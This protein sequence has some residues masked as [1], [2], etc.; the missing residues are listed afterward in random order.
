MIANSQNAVS[1]IPLR[2]Y[3]AGFSLLESLIVI[4]IVTMLALGGMNGLGKTKNHTSLTESHAIILYALENARGD[5]LSGVGSTDHGVLIKENSIIEFEGTSYIEGEGEKTD[6]IG[7]TVTDQ[8]GTEIIFRRLSGGANGDFTITLSNKGEY[9]LSVSV[10]QN[11][12]I[13]P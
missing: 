6:L 3:Q 5:A 10:L 7:A 9:S 13:T 4:S 2:L 12:T 1:Q 8:I 11:G